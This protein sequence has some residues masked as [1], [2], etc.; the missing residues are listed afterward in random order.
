MGNDN[1][2]KTYLDILK[3]ENV[4]TAYIQIQ[5]DIQSGIAHI[6]VAGNG[7]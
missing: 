2:A 7:M 3:K 6:T 1:Y 5:K 4:D